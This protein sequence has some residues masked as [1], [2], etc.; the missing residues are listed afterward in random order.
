METL[1]TNRH[2][3]LSGEVIFYMAAV[4]LRARRC[5]NRNR[6]LAGEFILNMAAVPLRARRNTN[7]NRRLAGEFILNTERRQWPCSCNLGT[8]SHHRLSVNYFKYGGSGTQRHK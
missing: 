7:R 1:G 4:P 5:T 3:R 2:C 6:R 8:S